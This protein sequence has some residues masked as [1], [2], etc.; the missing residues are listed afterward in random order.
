M[1]AYVLTDLGYGDCC[2][3]ATT[4]WLCSTRNVGTVIRSG[5]PQALHHVVA[6]NGEEHTFSQFGSGSLLGARTHLSRHM[7][8]EPYALLQEGRALRDLGIPDIFERTTIH[9]DVLVI[10]PFQ[11][12]A[13]RL[14]EIA[15]GANRHGTVGMGVG[16]AVL[17]AEALGDAAVRASDLGKP[18]LRDKLAAIRELKLKQLTP[19]LEWGLKELP[20]EVVEEAD[21]LK[22]PKI[23]DWSQDE[24]SYLGQVVSIVDDAFFADLLKS[25][26]VLVFEP[27]QG[28]LL[29]RWFGW[30]PHTTKVETSSSDVLKLLAEFD[31]QGEVIRLGLTRSYT[32]RHG[33]GP[34]VTEDKTLTQKLP[35][36]VNGDHKWQGGFRVGQLDLVALRYAIKAC[37]GP[38]AFNG[39]V[40]SCMDRLINPWQVCNRYLPGEETNA[41]QAR[42]FFEMEDGQITGIRLR[43]N[44]WDED[45]LAHQQRLGQLLRSCQPE[46][47][48]LN[49][50]KAGKV[51]LGSSGTKEF[52]SLLQDQLEVP[53]AVASFGPTE[54]DKIELLRL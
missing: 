8:I 28:V 10:T 47:L 42:D 6:A 32:T 38:P 2:K 29:N 51:G 1:K 48:T 53:V 23:V 13:S 52:L 39:L 21:K 27:S 9:Q 41:E 12:M 34:F 18:W 37:G 3:G 44:S 50:P 25:E 5:G 36:V 45:Q 17:D 54:L 31:Y 43:P 24:F 20:E 46:L 40:V 11:T 16:E 14:Q 15:R 4:H 49:S 30:H 7:V 19:L 33:A 22:N 26:R 35:D